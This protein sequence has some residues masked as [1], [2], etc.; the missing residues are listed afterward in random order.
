MKRVL[1][2][3]VLAGLLAAPARAANPVVVVETSLGTIKI[4]LDR[5]KAPIT[6]KNFLSYVDEKFYD[7]TVFHRV[8]GKENT[9]DRE[10]FFVQA[11]RFTGDHKE[12]MTRAP[13]K[14][15]AGNGLTNTRGSVA[16]ARADD[17]DS[18]TSQFFINL[19]DNK[20]FDKSDQGPGYTVFGKVIQG[21]E[22]VDKIKAVRTG[23][24]KFIVRDGDERT[25]MN[26]PEEDVVIKSVRLEKAK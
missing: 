3:A 5:D 20:V 9:R 2:L 25:F 18:A 21:M 19:K 12:K 11:G 23:E 13:I 7:D 14:S 1:L 16:M 8:L 26:V 22:V 17:A 6:V 10:D 4:E 24:K 15:E